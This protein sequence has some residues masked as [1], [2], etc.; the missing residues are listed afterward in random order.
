MIRHD[1]M[2]SLGLCCVLTTS[3][4]AQRPGRGPEIAKGGVVIPHYFGLP[5][6]S[7]PGTLLSTDPQ[8][9]L[10]VAP[11]P[12]QD[13]ASVAIGVSQSPAT[14]SES[15]GW[16]GV[17]HLG[18]GGP[19]PAGSNFVIQPRDQFGNAVGSMMIHEVNGGAA[20]ITVESSFCPTCPVDAELVLNGA[21]IRRGSFTAA[22]F[23][24]TAA[25]ANNG[26]NGI[27]VRAARK[28]WTPSNFKLN[29]RVGLP[30][31]VMI[32]LNDGQAPVQC[33]QMRL[34]LNGLP[35]GTRYIGNLALMGTGMGPGGFG[36]SNEALEVN[37]ALHV[38]LGQAHMLGIGD[39]DGDGQP[40]ISCD[41]IGSSGNDGVSLQRKLIPITS[42]DITGEMSSIACNPAAVLAQGSVS[43]FSVTSPAAGGAPAQVSSLHVV[44][45]GG[46][47]GAGGQ[48]ALS[49]ERC[50]PCGPYSSIVEAIRDGVVVDTV[51]SATAPASP[52]ATCNIGS[53]GQDGVRFTAYRQEVFNDTGSQGGRSMVF[54][55]DLPVT[56]TCTLAGSSTGAVSAD[57][58]RVR[59]I[60]AS[61]IV[62]EI[63]SVSLTGAGMP[64]FNTTRP[65]TRID[66]L[67]ARLTAL[68]FIARQLGDSLVTIQPDGVINVRDCDDDGDG[69]ELDFGDYAGVA[70][71]VLLGGGGGGSIS[72]P[73][74]ALEYKAKQGSTGKTKFFDDDSEGAGG[75]NNI[76]F[77]SLKCPTCP[78]TVEL[79]SGGRVVG[80]QTYVPPLPP[81]LASRSFRF[82]KIKFKYPPAGAEFTFDSAVPITLHNGPTATAS[83]I[84]MSLQGLPSGPIAD[85]TSTVSI[86]GSSGSSFSVV[87]AAVSK[88]PAGFVTKKS[89]GQ[90]AGKKRVAGGGF[91]GPDCA[92]EISN[93]GSSGE[94]GAIVKSEDD[95]CDGTPD[96]ADHIDVNVSSMTLPAGSR[97]AIKEK[98]LCHRIA[99]AAGGEVPFE[100]T[101]TVTGTASTHNVGVDFSGIDSFTCMVQVRSAGVLQGGEG[102]VAGPVIASVHHAGHAIVGF[103]SARY[104]ESPSLVWSPR[105]NIRWNGPVTV[106]LPSGAAFVGDELVITAENPSRP[107]EGIISMTITGMDL[108]GDELIVLDYLVEPVPYCGGDVAVPIDGRVNTDDLIALIGSWG[109]CVDCGSCAGDIVPPSGVG[110]GACEVNTDDLIVLIGS[111]GACP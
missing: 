57:R 12:G 86:T 76:G 94:D 98:G 43:N 73:S 90:L 18:P 101:C 77:E 95:D 99:S 6:E 22:N 36:I 104:R 41:N 15:P 33:D 47:G 64:A 30:T 50:A 85:L 59:C 108:P 19:L 9:M 103:T 60:P 102:G 38:A 71:T 56:G 51:W 35:P 62:P 52:F 68:G 49:L 83:T 61:G 107:A 20:D 81:S 5:H 46:G 1:L 70:G 11:E 45:S 63:E 2:L 92:L 44:G 13:S 7:A 48:A 40:E 89:N 91:T 32:S 97:V 37:D 24:A 109:Q 105:S 80:S 23:R 65:R 4:T 74:L 100:A 14:G 25:L 72:S 54:E 106:E 66:E 21:V 82:N 10:H 16:A 88:I 67:E 42:P 34:S 28:S 69:V 79:I 8:G 84:R 17:V 31:P 29:W 3:A 111:W 55:C 96:Y 58:V 53:S 39:L 26:G 110:Q 87:D 78:V 75:P 93:I 27:E